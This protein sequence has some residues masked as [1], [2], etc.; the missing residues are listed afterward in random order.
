MAVQRSD[1]PTEFGGVQG[2]YGNTDKGDPLR[3]WLERTSLTQTNPTLFGE[4][5]GS[6]SPSHGTGGKQVGTS[7]VS[8]KVTRG[9]KY[10]HHTND[11]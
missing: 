7:Y 11:S 8:G 2:I 4:D 10:G 1:T 9:G 6:A 3:P 5:N